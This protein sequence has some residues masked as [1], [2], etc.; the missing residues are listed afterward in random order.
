MVLRCICVSGLVTPHKGQLEVDPSVI[1]MGYEG[2]PELG[3]R[4][5]WTKDGSILV[6]AKLEQDVPEY[7]KYLKDKGKQF[8]DTLKLS[9]ED[10]NKVQD[11]A[12]LFGAHLMGRWKSVTAML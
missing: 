1:I 6:F 2:D 3:K 8:L 10:R 5:S 11:P 7:N 12:G 9:A 4:P